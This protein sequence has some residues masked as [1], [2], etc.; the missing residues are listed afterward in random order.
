T[1]TTLAIAELVISDSIRL[2]GGN[3]YDEAHFFRRFRQLSH[4]VPYDTPVHLPGFDGAFAFR[5]AGHILGSASVEIV[6]PRSRVI[7]SGDLGRPDS[8]ILRDYCET[9]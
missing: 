1:R 3:H 6:T 4:P 9:W 7:C 5:E 2:A 8:P